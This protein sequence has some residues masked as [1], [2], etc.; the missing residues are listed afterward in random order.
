MCVQLHGWTSSSKGQARRPLPC[1]SEPNI[2]VVSVVETPLVHANRLPALEKIWYDV[3]IKCAVPGTR[4]AGEW[5]HRERFGDGG[6][7]G[8][9]DHG[10]SASEVVNNMGMQLI[11]SYGGWPT[12]SYILSSSSPART[13]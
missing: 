5:G 2:G 8:K 9:R 12:S 10:S 4:A 11:H 1:L 13:S 3:H 7:G 6:G